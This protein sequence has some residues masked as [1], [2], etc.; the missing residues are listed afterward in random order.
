MQQINRIIIPEQGKY[1]IVNYYEI[2]YFEGQGAY[3]IIHLHKSNMTIP[4]NLKHVE[5]NL[6]NEMFVRIHQ[7]YIINLNHITN[8]CLNNKSSVTIL[9]K[10][11]LPVSRNYKNNLIQKLKT[12]F[13]W[14]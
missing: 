3:S 2:Q 13:E 1:R 7:S 6:N 9:G 4:K 10:K 8:C 11:S 14:L 5:T 12:H